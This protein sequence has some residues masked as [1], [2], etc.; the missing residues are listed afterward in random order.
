MKTLSFA[1]R[2][3][4]RFANSLCRHSLWPKLLDVS[5]ARLA[6]SLCTCRKIYMLIE[7]SVQLSRSVILSMGFE[8][9][10][11]NGK[12]KTCIVTY[13]VS[14]GSDQPARSVEAQIS[15]RIRAGRSEPSLSAWHA[16]ELQVY[17]I[18]VWNNDDLDQ[19]RHTGWSR[20]TQR[21]IVSYFFLCTTLPGKHVGV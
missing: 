2:I 4:W 19:H 8:H 7:D 14:E 9:G 11:W 21:Q 13:A 3:I 6:G 12:K 10:V 16:S 5:S 18:H 20:R 17:H 1:I 15:P